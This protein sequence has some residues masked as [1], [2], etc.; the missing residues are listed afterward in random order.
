M[1]KPLVDAVMRIPAVAGETP[2]GTVVAGSTL[3]G[4]SVAG[5]TLVGAIVVAGLIGM[6]ADSVL[7]ATLRERRFCRVCGVTTEQRV[8]R[9]GERTQHASGLAWLTNDTVNFLATCVGAGV[10]MGLLAVVGR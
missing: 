2:V 6:L 10:G 7:G 3:V 1:V 9:C 5:N 4:A 8:H